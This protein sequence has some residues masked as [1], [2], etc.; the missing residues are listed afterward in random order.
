[1]ARRVVVT[2]LGGVTPV[3]NNVTDIWN[4]LLQ[5]KS[6]IGPITRFDA[7]DYTTQFGGEVKNFDPEALFGSKEA[8]RMDRLTHF[9]LEAG[10]QAIEDAGLPQANVDRTRTGVIIGSAMG[11]VAT[12]LAQNNILE[13]KGVRRVSPFTIPMMLPDTPAAQLAI[14]YGYMGPSMSITS[15]CATGTNAVGEAFEMIARDS[16]D[17]IVAGGADSLIL[18]I[19]FAGFCVMK[20]FS[21]RNED[22]QGACRPFDIDRDGF[23]AAEGAA[24]LVLEEL[25]H[26]KARGATIYAEF[27]GYGAS[28]DANNMASPLPDGSG[29][30]LAMKAAIRRA[31]IAPAEVDY[32]NAHGTST[33]LND[34]A[35]TN[36]V[37]V[38][39]GDHAYKIAVSSTKSMTGHLLGG[40]GA[41][42]AI[43]CAKTLQTGIIAPTINYHKPDPECDLDY[44]P[45]V[46]RE[47]DVQIAMSNSFG[48]G[49]HNATVVLKK[50]NEL[51]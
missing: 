24:V 33:Q 23:V 50:Y 17:I 9:A 39:L 45:N 37:K 43:V 7:S 36:A 14:E 15:A 41:L 1:M 47:R 25:E 44:T 12:L 16:A 46:A 40:A 35:E 5:G 11:G 20:A 48:F 8:R 30:A 18:P 28:V 29:A 10:R 42:E 19:I 34:P 22:P 3:G 13:A 51:N 49:G 38:V 4:N 6:G 26:A 32:L 21:T 31:G 27:I 2:G